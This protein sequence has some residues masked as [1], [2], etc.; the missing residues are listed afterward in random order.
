M[1]LPIPS[2]WDGKK[3]Q[4][5]QIQWPDS[6]LWFAILNGLI[7]GL[8]AGRS[9]D[10][11][12]GSILDVQSIGR[13]I[14]ARSIP[15]QSCSGEIIP[16]TIPPTSGGGG[17]WLE[18]VFEMPCIDLSSMIDISRGDG[19]LWVLDGCC[20]W[21]DLGEFGGQSEELITIPPGETQD[22]PIPFSACGKA[23]S[24]V[25]V[26]YAVALALWGAT[27]EEPWNYVNAVKSAVSPVTVKAKY[28][29]E[30][31]FLAA[32]LKGTGFTEEEIFDDLSKQAIVCRLARTLAADTGALSAANISAIETAF[33]QNLEFEVALFSAAVKAIGTS[34]LSNISMAGQLNQEADCDCPELVPPVSPPTDSGPW[35]T[36]Q[37]IK[38]SGEG[39]VAFTS[40]NASMRKI[41]L[42]WLVPAPGFASTDWIGY[43]MMTTPVALTSVTFKLTGE[44]PLHDWHS[45]PYSR[46]LDPHIATVGDTVG[47]T[48]ELISADATGAVVKVSFPSALPTAYAAEVA[49]S[50]R[51]LPQD[52][53]PGN[54]GSATFQIE[55][56]D[57]ELA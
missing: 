46:W 51:F 7:A 33:N 44:Y 35:F 50:F 29:I 55:I 4:C 23:D 22:P 28:V 3:W 54:G 53:Q 17:L 52:T 10:E 12:D 32:S 34:Q 24:I 5:V 18:E 36:G 40:L 47:A 9:W 56:L 14:W 38:S 25:N 8:A 26:I 13:E 37:I 43:I 48:S 27:S 6:P 42:R 2:D 11:R 57:F 41:G 31:I 16:P 15:F 1:R 49:N 19:H 20:N 45:T 30:G 21:V 39:V